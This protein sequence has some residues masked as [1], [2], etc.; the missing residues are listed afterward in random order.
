MIV[1]KNINLNYRF[2]TIKHTNRQLCIFWATRSESYYNYPYMLR[3]N[4][5]FIDNEE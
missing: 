3:R 4:W 2:R 5:F 1:N